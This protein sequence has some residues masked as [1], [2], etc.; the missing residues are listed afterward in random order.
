[1]ERGM[2]R[3]SPKAV[4]RNSGR[5]VIVSVRMSAEERADLIEDA[6]LMGVSPSELLRRLA[7]QAAGLGP[8]LTAPDRNVLS[9]VISSLRQIAMRLEGLERATRQEG[10]VMPD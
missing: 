1:M 6:G 9:D 4:S 7:G 2:G 5:G 10:I 8:V 3:L